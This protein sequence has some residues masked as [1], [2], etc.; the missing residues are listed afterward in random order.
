MCQDDPYTI[1]IMQGDNSVKA[2]DIC[3]KGGAGM[4]QDNFVQNS[5]SYQDQNVSGNIM[6]DK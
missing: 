5:E 4:G 6:I 3:L 2:M 1:E